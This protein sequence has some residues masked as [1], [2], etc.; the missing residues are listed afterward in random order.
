VALSVAAATIGLLVALYRQK[1]LAEGE[2]LP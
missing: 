1:A 2:R